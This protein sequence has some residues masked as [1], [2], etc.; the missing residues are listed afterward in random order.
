LTGSWRGWG[1]YEVPTTGCSAYVKPDLAMKKIINTK[2]D[3]QAEARY[4]D[5]DK[6]SPTLQE[7]H[8]IL[9]GKPLPNSKYFELEKITQ[10]RLY[11]K[12]DL[13]EF[14]LSSDRAA[15]SFSKRKSVKDIIL[16]IPKAETDK[17]YQI[18]NTI[19]GI[20]IWPSNRIDK[21]MTINGARGFNAKIADRFDLTIE[22]VRR[23]YL[24]ID[25]PL[26]ETFKRYADFF[27]LFGNFKGFINF[28]LLQDIVSID[29]SMVKIATNFNDFEFSSIP[30][31]LEEYI[32][33]MKNTTEFIKA[34]NARID[35]WANYQS[36]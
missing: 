8:R 30:T 21:K 4:R 36:Q 25:S 34:R 13:G 3:F 28:F 31:S 12:S 9:W 33:Y 23:Y 20:L 18:R 19:G 22:C 27:A 32:I 11:H 10:N 2:F 1:G 15:T 7:Y 6:Y 14:F 26:T 16:Q 35:R 29:Y 24:N 5:S 17:F